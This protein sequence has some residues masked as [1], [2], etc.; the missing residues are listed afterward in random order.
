[1]TEPRLQMMEAIARKQIVEADY[2]GQR[3]RLAPHLLFERHGDLFVSAL[4]LGKTWRSD[5]EPRLGQFKLAGLG[6]PALLDEPFE[7][8]PTF[9]PQPPRETDTLLL[10]V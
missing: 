4:N 10:A 2:N 1:M 7:T 5:E 8:L 3:I 9:A 6:N